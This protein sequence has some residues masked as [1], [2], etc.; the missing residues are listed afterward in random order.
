MT[1]TLI[2]AGVVVLSIAMVNRRKLLEMRHRERLAMIEHGV[3]PAP[4]L[5]P[6]GFERHVLEMRPPSRS[7][8]RFRS[9]GIL[10]I[11]VG[12]AL[13]VLIGFAGGAPGPGLGVGGAAALIGLALLLNGLFSARDEL[14]P[15]ERAA[16]HPG[17]A[18]PTPPEPPT[19]VAP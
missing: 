6:S 4:E 1:V 11:G 9:A 7:S 13:M 17:T 5:D 18:S 2:I 12:L 3:V 16:A 14:L 10:M 8:V 15:D 19:N